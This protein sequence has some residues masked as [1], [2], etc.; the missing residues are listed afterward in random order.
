MGSLPAGVSRDALLTSRSPSTIRRAHTALNADRQRVISCVDAGKSS[1][2][3]RPAH[4][5]MAT[6]MKLALMKG[7]AVRRMSRVAEQ[8]QCLRVS[9]ARCILLRT[10]SGHRTCLNR[11]SHNSFVIEYVLTLQVDFS[12]RDESVN[13]VAPPHR[14][15]KK[16]PGEPDSPPGRTK[17]DVPLTSYLTFDLGPLT[18]Y[19][20]L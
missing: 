18:L 8:R 9:T 2:R 10:A 4:T 20:D 11:M 19:L 12:V 17:S 6:T 1:V 7:V 5:V 3:M 16:W 14:R 13:S 15:Q